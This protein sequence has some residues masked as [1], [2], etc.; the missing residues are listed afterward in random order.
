MK[1][2]DLDLLSLVSGVL[3]AGLGVVFALKATGTISLDLGIVP[4]LVFIVIGL[5]VCASVVTAMLGP[6]PEPATVA[7]DDAAGGHD[8]ERTDS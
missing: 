1:R 6:G 2:H 5:A 8:P 3:F 4:A 7:R